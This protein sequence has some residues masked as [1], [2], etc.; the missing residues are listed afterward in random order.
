MSVRQ[1]W[2]YWLRMSLPKRGR[3][4]W[5]K[6]S[7]L[8][9]GKKK[10]N[11]KVGFFFI[12]RGKKERSVRTQRCSLRARD[13]KSLSKDWQLF[14]II[15]ITLDF[16]C[17]SHA[18]CLEN[19]EHVMLFYLTVFLFCAKI[20]G[21]PWLPACF[22]F[23][24][25]ESEKKVD[26]EERYPGAERCF[27]PFRLLNQKVIVQTFHMLQVITLQLINFPRSNL[28]TYRH[29]LDTKTCY[30]KRYISSIFLT[31]I[32]KHYI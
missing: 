6:F 17:I 7:E 1:Q 28:H 24:V 31:Y 15:H 2:L 16:A 22:N 20:Y 26:E 9:L 25:P 10:K 23:S 4:R 32:A 11:T 8:H 18:V 29:F 14:W 12:R 27:K 19:Y 13:A 3:E 30:P 21:N 5:M